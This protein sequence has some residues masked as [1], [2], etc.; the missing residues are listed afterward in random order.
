MHYS[1]LKFISQVYLLLSL[2]IAILPFS[3]N[4]FWTKWMFGCQ[5][6]EK[7]K[8]RFSAMPIIYSYLKYIFFYLSVLSYFLLLHL[9]E[10]VLNWRLDGQDF[11]FIGF[12]S[13][14]GNLKLM[15]SQTSSYLAVFNNCASFSRQDWDW[16]PLLGMFFPTII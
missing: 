10:L 5:C 16:F 12:V 7:C 11:H 3:L 2:G 15:I 1:I 13:G 14:A 6:S 8:F 9:S 4:S